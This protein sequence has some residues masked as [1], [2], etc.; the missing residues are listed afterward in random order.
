ML[1]LKIKY[2]IQ[3]LF[4]TILFKIGFNKFLLRNRYGERII[5]FHGIDKKG[6]TKFNSRFISEKYFEHFIAFI[7]KNYNVISLD[8]FYA[9]K[10]KKNTLNIAITFDDGYANNYNYAVPILKKH[11]VPAS[12][13]ITT[14]HNK[15]DFLW[16]DFI[17]LVSF[18][19]NKKA[20]IFNGKEFV[21]KKNEFYS[22]SNSLKSELKN[23]SFD[24]IQQVYEIFNGDWQKIKQQNFDDYWQLM[25]EKQIEE[26]AK[27]HLFT[28]G[29]HG[30]THSNLIAIS[31]N[32]SKQEILHSKNELEK[33]CNSHITEF[34]F[35]FGYYSDELVEYCR[36]IG[37]SKILL[38]DYNNNE[39]KKNEL[40]KNRFVINPY[41][42]FEQQLYFL[43]RGKY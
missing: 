15:N 27:H 20:I 33:I 2:R 6:E 14:I 24:K 38:V 28:I 29:A 39:D 4:Q 8:D 34:A 41:I 12:F 19:S 9:K 26:I 16:A 43:L 36:E 10:F 37:Y 13:Y 18:Y 1:W 7:T 17:D 35:P 5:V 30:S 40:L 21:K 22:G 32:E 42:S 25:T 31:T 11:N 23:V 3:L